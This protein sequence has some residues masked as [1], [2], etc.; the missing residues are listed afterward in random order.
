VTVG[1]RAAREILRLQARGDVEWYQTRFEETGFDRRES[2]PTPMF[3][4]IRLREM[5]LANRVVVSPMA[6]YSAV[7]G[8]PD[9]WHF[10]HDTS[11]AGRCRLVY[12]EMTCPSADARISPGCTGLWNDAQ[13]RRRPPSPS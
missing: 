5:A 13:E 4:P 10:V 9:H 12:V 3:A 7:D 1:E 8:V 2:R 6:Q 11:R